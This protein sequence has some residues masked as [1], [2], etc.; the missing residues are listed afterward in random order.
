MGGVYHMKTRN[1]RLFHCLYFQRGRF[2]HAYC[3]LV[4]SHRCLPLP[5][6]NIFKTGC[7]RIVRTVTVC[8]EVWQRMSRRAA[9]QALRQTQSCTGYQTRADPRGVIPTSW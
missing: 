3:P 2:L 6:R 9:L 4:S 8:I 5:P 7:G 1:T